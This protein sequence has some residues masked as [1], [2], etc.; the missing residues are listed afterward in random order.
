MSRQ[1]LG[2]SM[3]D[4]LSTTYPPVKLPSSPSFPFSSSPALELVRKFCRASL[5]LG[6]VVLGSLS[7]LAAAGVELDNG[8]TFFN[9]P[10]RLLKSAV[11]TYPGLGALANYRFTISLP[12]DAGQPLQSLSITQHGNIDSVHFNISQT[13]ASV[14]GSAVPLAS[15]GGSAPENSQEVIVVFDPPIQPG[16]TVSV[17]L[18]AK[19]PPSRGVYL[20]GVTA[21]PVGENSP[22]LYLGSGR[23]TF[24]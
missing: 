21:F 1:H 13:Y 18:R 11:T 15:I 5:V 7:T 24:P 22:G 14:G 3:L 10:P 6:T 9:H 8:Q 19:R 12:D 16:S 23:V 20:F 17:S 4:Q 2:V